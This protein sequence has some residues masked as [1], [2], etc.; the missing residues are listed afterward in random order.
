M[1]KWERRESSSYSKM[2]TNKYRRNEG[3]KPWKDPAWSL[4]VRDYSVH[5]RMLLVSLA[6]IQLD[7]SNTLSQLRQPKVSS[8]IVRRSLGAKSCWLR[9]T[10]LVFNG[11]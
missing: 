8:D 7:A 2:L 5:C 11:C 6:S 1:N 10:D 4:I 3:L 9:M